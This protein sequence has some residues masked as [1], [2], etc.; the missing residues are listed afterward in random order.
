MKSLVICVLLTSLFLIVRS[1]EIK[2][3]PDMEE[4]KLNYFKTAYAV[5][6]QE[7]N[8]HWIYYIIHPEVFDI[9]KDRRISKEELCQALLTTLYID[10][11]LDTVNKIEVQ[12]IKDKI[13][14]FVISLRTPFFNFK[15]MSHLISTVKHEQ[16]F[17]IIEM[18][19]FQRGVKENREIE[20]DL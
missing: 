19:K 1:N 12:R 16:V 18:M 5:E 9:N 6:L 14:Q 11:K 2:R 3:V 13:K 10:V 7:K 8:K 20:D 17:S 4:D 15:Q